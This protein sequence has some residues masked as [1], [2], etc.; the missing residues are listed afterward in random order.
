VPVGK[1]SKI[2]AWIHALREYA[3]SAKVQA[4]ELGQRIRENPAQLWHSPVARYTAITLAGVMALLIIRLV[5]GALTPPLPKNA[6]EPSDTAIFY[7]MCSDPGCSKCGE[8]MAI[9]RKHDFDRFPVTC[10]ACGKKTGQRAHK[11]KSG[12]H[13]G[14]WMMQLRR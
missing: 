4:V 8:P 13:K 7:I 11:A 9:Q 12:P 10:P 6:G 1:E 5:V 14:K 2:A 3:P